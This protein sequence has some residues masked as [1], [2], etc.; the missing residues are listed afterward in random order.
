VFALRGIA[1]SFSVF[2]LVYCALSLAVSFAWHSCWLHIQRHPAR[3]I[4]D[5][6]FALR[7]FPLASAAIITAVF[8]IPSFVLLEPRAIVEPVGEIPLVLGICG[9]AL[10]LSGVVNAAL[11]MRRASR[12]IRRW[13]RQ[14]QPIKAVAPVPVLRIARRIPPMMAAGIARPRVLVSSAAEFMLSAHELQSAL[15]HEV[16]H[17]RRRDNLKKLLL[18]FVA[19]PGM[20]TLET[21]WLETSE[22]AADDAAVANASEALDLAAALIKLS[23]LGPVE[24]HIDLTA[25]LVHSPASVMNARVERLIAWSEDRR[26][27]QPRRSPWLGVSAMLATVAAFAITYSQLLIHV[28]TATE[29]LVR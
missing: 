26:V 8:T 5:L 11:A 22:M 13:T 25:A 15:N 19:F 4:A 28:H 14:A 16:A 18:R 9:A 12:T 20:T 24:S 1:V 10:G 29:W 21:A 23:R 3:R 6:L 2:V 27:P 7:L 17:V